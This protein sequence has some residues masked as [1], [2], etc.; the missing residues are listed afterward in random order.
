MGTA[1]TISGGL[2]NITPAAALAVWAL[3]TIWL[4]L[5]LVLEHLGPIAGED[6]IRP[7]TG[8][9]HP[10][11]AAPFRSFGNGS[12]GGWVGQKAS[13]MSNVVK[14]EEFKIPATA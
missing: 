11:L 7:D 1:K 9:D 8:G 3:G 5:F 10:P 13:G 2:I 6:V 14:A 12:P 4:L